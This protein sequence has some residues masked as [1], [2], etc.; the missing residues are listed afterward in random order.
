M[1]NH[2]FLFIEYVTTL[3]TE[4]EQQK[5]ENS[6]LKLEIKWL[7]SKME[8][9]QGENDKLRLDLVLGPVTL[10]S[11][12]QQ[13]VLHPSP[14][15]SLLSTTPPSQDDNWDFIL[16]DFNSEQH[17]NTF[18]SQA[19]VPTWNQVFLS[20]EQE[21]REPSVDLLKQYPL[22]APAL[23]SII[24]SHTMTMNTDQLIASAKFSNSFIQQQQQQQY[25][26][27]SSPN[28]TN[29]EAQIIWNLLEPLRVVK[30]R[31]EKLAEKS[32]DK[33]DDQTN[34]DA[35]KEDSKIICP[36]TRCVI[37]WLQYTVCGHISKMIAKCNDT[38]IEEKPLLC[39]SYQRAMKYI[40]A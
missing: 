28:M 4:L 8:K 15:M 3:E 16:P 22:L 19:V 33:E 21:Q 5:A 30:E 20:K 1:T 27:P 26:I 9:L 18:I 6:Q 35:K 37:T 40:Y 2:L 25:L 11:S 38:P 23:M 14:D 7:K 39:R 17:Q 32:N 24:L 31:N 13:L 12:Q 34:E 29:K 10:P 36:I